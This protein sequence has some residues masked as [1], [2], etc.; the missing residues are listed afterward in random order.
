MN[1]A[2]CA[3][4]CSKETRDGCPKSKNMKEEEPGKVEGVS[5]GEKEGRGRN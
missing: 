5:K 1:K 2:N 4:G 3:R